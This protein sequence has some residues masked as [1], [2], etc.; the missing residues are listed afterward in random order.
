VLRGTQNNFALSRSWFCAKGRAGEQHLPFFES[1]GLLTANSNRHIAV[2][3]RTPNN[4]GILK[5]D[6]ALPSVVPELAPT[7]AVN[8]RLVEPDGLVK[9]PYA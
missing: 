8:C 3:S 5:S 1:S 2:E 9:K 4:S 7:G 6:Q